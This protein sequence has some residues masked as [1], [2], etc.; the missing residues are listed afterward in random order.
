VI[1]RGWNSTHASRG[2][3]S[4]RV[5]RRS[6]P[7]NQTRR[8]GISPTHTLIVTFPAPSPPAWR[9]GARPTWARA[10]APR[11]PMPTPRLRAPGAPCSA[12]AALRPPATGPAMARGGGTPAWLGPTA[13]WPGPAGGDEGGRGQRAARGW[14]WVGCVQVFW[15]HQA[16]AIRRHGRQA[17]HPPKRTPACPALWAAA[18]LTTARCEPHA[19]GHPWQAGAHAS[20]PGGHA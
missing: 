17:R 14:H 16:A 2:G 12:A 13:G 18:H 1:Q 5:T 8:K 9:S 20:C 7:K 15:T 10:R 11:A 6:G 4:G 3:H 19:P